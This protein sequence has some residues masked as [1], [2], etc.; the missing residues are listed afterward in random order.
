MMSIYESLPT[1]VLSVTGAA[2]AGT[3]CV[4]RQENHIFAT[5]GK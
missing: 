1:A 2:A 3:E 5:D 4:F